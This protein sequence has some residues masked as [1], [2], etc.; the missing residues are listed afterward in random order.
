VVVAWRALRAGSTGAAS[1][2]NQTGVKER[3]MHRRRGDRGG[4]AGEAAAA[5]RAGERLGTPRGQ[6]ERGVSGDEWGRMGGALWFMPRRFR[7]AG[8]LFCATV[9]LALRVQF[10]SLRSGSGRTNV[11][12]TPPL[13][14]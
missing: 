11:N 12:Q 5:G 10:F 13:D 14:N 7:L 1:G 9:V 3:E 6:G 2:G 8:G 4:Q